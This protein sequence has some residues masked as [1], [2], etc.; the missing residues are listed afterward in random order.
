MLIR[1]TLDPKETTPRRP[2]SGGGGAVHAGATSR[3]GPGGRGSA[4]S[5]RRVPGGKQGAGAGWVHRDFKPDIR[6]GDPG[7]EAELDGGETCAAGTAWRELDRNLADM[8]RASP[9]VHAPD[10]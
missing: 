2:R 8:T 1:G 6:R 4:G 9:E 7:Q 10:E 5:L 3:A